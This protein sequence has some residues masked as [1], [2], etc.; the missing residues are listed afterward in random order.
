[1][2]P[3]RSDEGTDKAKTVYGGNYSRLA[4]IKSKRDPHNLFHVNQ[5]VKPG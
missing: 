3:R 1:M 5:N 2:H 4:Q